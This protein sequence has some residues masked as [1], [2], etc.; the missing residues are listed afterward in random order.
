MRCM[1]CSGPETCNT[2]AKWVDKT[3]YKSCDPHRYMSAPNSVRLEPS[4]DYR[5]GVREG[6]RLA[7]DTVCD[8]LAGLGGTIAKAIREEEK[9]T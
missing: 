5:D 4:Q 1:W 3:G 2:D 6:L 8:K 9:K 7:G